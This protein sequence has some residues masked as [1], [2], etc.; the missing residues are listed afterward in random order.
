M[1]EGEEKHGDDVDDDEVFPL[2]K[3]ELY[4]IS[5]LYTQM[6]SL[7]THPTNNYNLCL[8]LLLCAYKY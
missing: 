8:R 4:L 3:I 1:E 2:S 7:A 6:H 5:I